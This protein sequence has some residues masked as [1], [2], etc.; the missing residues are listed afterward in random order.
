MSKIVIWH[1]SRCSKSKEAKEILEKSNQEFEIFEYLKEPLN[2]ESLKEIIKL[3]GIFDIRQM[4]RL[5]ESEYKEF[6]IANESLSQDK[7]IDIVIKNPK[8]IERPI[9]IKN[10]KAVIGRPMDNVINLVYK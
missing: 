8:L 6:D 4:M 2:K 3:L 10:S 9:V 5:K 1:N 7:I